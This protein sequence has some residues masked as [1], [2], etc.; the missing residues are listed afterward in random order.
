MNYREVEAL[1]G[2]DYRL[3]DVAV[4][5]LRHELALLDT[6]PGDIR[7]THDGERLVALWSVR[8]T[9]GNNLTRTVFMEPL[10]AVE[11]DGSRAL[12]RYIIKNR[13][14]DSPI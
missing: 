13:R 5:S 1:L 3:I 11:K 6:A 7:V 4:R 10:I 9:F 14:V 2:P 12:A 8:S